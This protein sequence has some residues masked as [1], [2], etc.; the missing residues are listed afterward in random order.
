MKVNIDESWKSELKEE[1][2]KPYFV[3]LTE[4]VKNEYQS[5]RCYPKGKAIFAAFDYCKFDDLKVVI[6]GQDPYHGVDQA[7]GLCFSV[8]DHIAMPPS[9]I[10]IFKEIEQDL[11]KP[12]PKTGN[13]ERWAKQGVLLL[14]ATL[15]V[16][17]HQAG[18][19]Q[20][21]GWEQFTDQ[22]ISTISAKKE[23]VVFLLWG[24]FA[25]KKAQLIDKNKHHILTS[26][27][28]SPLSANRGYW[29]GNKHFSKTN[30]FLKSKHL[31]PVEW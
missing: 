25:K 10:N 29:F 1:F 21:K 15:T 18:S 8:K 7:N 5:H 2:E 14:N 19:H 16:R 17:A 9:L 6:I 20:G 13:L 11:T 4:F 23:N 28:P 30:A 27:H 31:E 24:G 12:F 3:Q 22:V 26:G